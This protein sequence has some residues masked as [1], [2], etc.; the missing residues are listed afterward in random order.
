MEL[1]R[2]SDEWK[3][4]VALFRTFA[5]KVRSNCSCQFALCKKIV[6]LIPL[7]LCWCQ[8][9][10]HQPQSRWKCFLMSRGQTSTR[11][12]HQVSLSSGRWRHLFITR[13]SSLCCFSHVVTFLHFSAFK[14]SSLI[15][16]SYT[17]TYR[18]LTDIDRIFF[19]VRFFVIISGKQAQF[20]PAWWRRRWGQWTGTH[21]PRVLHQTSPPKQVSSICSSCIFLICG[22][23]RFFFFLLIT[24][25]LKTF[26]SLPLLNRPMYL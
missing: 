23:C 8:C 10:G 18:P 1:E 16:P 21:Q 6:I 12:S 14:T 3:R 20:P 11:C 5:N 22:C 7:H 13:F 4:H 9:V 15:L 25:S 2:G 19:V 17:T 24:C 26:M